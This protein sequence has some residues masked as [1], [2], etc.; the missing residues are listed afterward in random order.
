MRSSMFWETSIRSQNCLVTLTYRGWDYLVERL[1]R[2]YPGKRL[3]LVSQRLP[4]SLLRGKLEPQFRKRGIVYKVLFLPDG[5][6]AKSIF[7]VGKLWRSLQRLKVDKSTP[8]VAIGGGS[9]GDVTGFVA[10]T[11]L[12]G[13]PW[14]NVPTTLLAQ[15]DSSVGGKAAIN[16]G[17]KNQVGSIYP[18]RWVYSDIAVLESLSREAW[19]SGLSEMIKCAAIQDAKFLRSLERLS[20]NTFLKT[21][22]KVFDHFRR[23]IEIK[24]K[25]VERDPF[26]QNGIRLRLNFGH[27]IGHAIESAN[28]FRLDHGEA[29]ARGML[30]EVGLT[31]KLGWTP[32][33]SRNRL[34]GLLHRYGLG[35]EGPLPKKSWRK[36]LFCD[37]K[38]RDDKIKL[39]VL[40]RIGQVRVREI[41]LQFLMVHHAS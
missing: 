27:T 36:F 41:P 17:A 32:E 4:W 6:R 13:I 34:E 2:F 33:S 12:R 5:E 26:D 8:L 39:P 30:E 23:A 20:L 11:Y 15:I 1:K 21:P 25:I 28:G 37:K 19:R 9:V 14:I 35:K 31:A 29:I 3:V 24:I 40:V 38:R 7:T 10:A 22:G 18:P 16:M